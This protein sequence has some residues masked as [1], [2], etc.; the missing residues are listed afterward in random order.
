MCRVGTFGLGPVDLALEVGSVCVVEGGNGAGKTTLLRVAAG[1]LPL[2]AGRR[3]CDGTA[4]YLRSG[5][6]ARDGQ[7]V[8][9]AVSSAVA[10]AGRRHAAVGD[11]VDAVGLA[12]HARH[13]VGML[14][15]GERARLTLAV[16]LAVRPSLVCLDEPFAHV[17][18]AGV[19]VVRDVVARLAA[20]GCAVMVASPQRQPLRDD[21]D[22]C[23]L[24]D[25]GMV[26]AA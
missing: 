7:R 20:A 11:V 3:R 17:D 10:L 14:S 19:G 1:L 5:A 2:S 23:L 12:G 9:E 24:V 13:R 16:A 22:A 25:D 4:L 26:R 18:A 15:A 8:R 21:S 6:G